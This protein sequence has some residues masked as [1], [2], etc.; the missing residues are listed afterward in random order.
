MRASHAD[1]EQ[2]IAVLKCAFVAGMLAKDEFDIRVGQTLASRTYSQLA[3]LTADLPASIA[4]AQPPKPARPRGGKPLLRPSQVITWATILYAAGWLYAPSPAAPAMAVMGGFFY[5]CVVAIAVAAGF[6]NRPDRRSGRQ[7]AQ[8]HADGAGGRASR[9]LPPAVPR[10]AGPAGRS[11]LSARRLAC[12]KSARTRS[13]L[14]NRRS[15]QLGVIRTAP[16]RA[17]EWPDAAPTSAAAPRRL[18]GN[19]HRRAAAGHDK[20]CQTDQDSRSIR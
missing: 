9:H 12:A 2:V 17:T 20:G 19:G 4:A 8:G 16:P 5:L 18:P 1:R 14:P 10:R 13:R 15:R 7:L 6:E 11:W 3:E